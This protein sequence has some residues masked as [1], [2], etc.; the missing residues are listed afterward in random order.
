MNRYNETINEKGVDESICK[1]AMKEA[2]LRL[3]E[4][5]KFENI[6]VTQISEKAFVN[7]GTFYFYFKSKE[8][9]YNEMISEAIELLQL[10][11]IIETFVGKDNK[12]LSQERKEL[13]KE[14]FIIASKNQKFLIKILDNHAAKNTLQNKIE[15]NLQQLAAIDGQVLSENLTCNM[16]LAFL[17]FILK[18]WVQQDSEYSD[19]GIEKMANIFENYLLSVIEIK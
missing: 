7:R 18:C 19:E 14:L 13:C 6:T 17:L 8:E 1:R 12:S 9:L 11:R 15:K 16:I 2:F 10:E 3:L 5:K 4:N